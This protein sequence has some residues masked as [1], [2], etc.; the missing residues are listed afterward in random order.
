MTGSICLPSH[1]AMQRHSVEVLP[2]DGSESL[3]TP[4]Q[5][6]EGTF[7][8]LQEENLLGV[9]LIIRRGCSIPVWESEP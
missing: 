4:R 9:L 3:E 8:F 5:M 7:K 1:D 6:S 2:Q